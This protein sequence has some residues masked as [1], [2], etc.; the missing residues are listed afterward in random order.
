M[1]GLQSLFK[2]ESV[3]RLDGYFSAFASVREVCFQVCASANF[4]K[5]IH[6]Y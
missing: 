2:S 6:I 5:K 3:L 4:K 1:G